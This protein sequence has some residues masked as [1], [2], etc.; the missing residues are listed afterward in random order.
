MA[1]RALLRAC[2][3]VAAEGAHQGSRG[4]AAMKGLP[5]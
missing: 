2:P 5:C 3:T 4:K 1:K